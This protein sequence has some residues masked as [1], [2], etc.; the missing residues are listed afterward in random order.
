MMMTGIG[1]PRSQR[2]IAGIEKFLPERVM[3]D[4]TGRKACCS[5]QGISKRMEVMSYLR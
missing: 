5:I 2:R 3:N 1:T 4:P